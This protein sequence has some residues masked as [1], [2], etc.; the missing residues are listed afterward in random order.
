MEKQSRKQQIT[1]DTLAQMVQRGF[2][3]QSAQVRSFQSEFE[4]F[5]R[6]TDKT[7]FELQSE[8]LTTN[9]RL[10]R[11]EKVLVP[12]MHLADA[13]KLNSRDHETRITRLEHQAGIGRR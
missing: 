3:E 2:A 9:E 4:D 1:L 10:D 12:L 7:L 13:L 5:R 6:K 8:A 11:I